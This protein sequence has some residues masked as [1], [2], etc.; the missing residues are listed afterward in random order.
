MFYKF[1]QLQFNNKFFLEEPNEV[2]FDVKSSFCQAYVQALWT[3]AASK[4][5]A[6]N[7]KGNKMRSAAVA[8]R[9]WFD[10]ANEFFVLWRVAKVGNKKLQFPKMLGS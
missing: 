8:R 5:L 7:S 6:V 2:F 10:G 1:S 3:L 9:T 4:G